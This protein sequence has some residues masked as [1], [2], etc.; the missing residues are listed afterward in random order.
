MKECPMCKGT[1]TIRTKVS[2]R[3]SKISSVKMLVARG[4]SYSEI[5]EIMGFKSKSTVAYYLKEN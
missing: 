5:A 1:G 4:H 3:E 2:K